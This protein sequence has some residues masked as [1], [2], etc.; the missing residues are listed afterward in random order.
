[1]FHRT[2]S[3]KYNN[4]RLNG[5]HIDMKSQ[6]NTGGSN[7]GRVPFSVDKSIP[8]SQRAQEQQIDCFGP[9][10]NR[11]LITVIANT[12][13]PIYFFPK[14]LKV[15]IWK[16]KTAALKK[17]MPCRSA[18][19]VEKISVDTRDCIHCCPVFNASNTGRGTKKWK[20]NKPF[21]QMISLLLTLG[22]D[23]CL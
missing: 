10:L 9:K 21:Y 13:L 19:W 7:K 2:V 3:S 1:M 4:R 18:L 11:I 12:C 6:A 15:S 22:H 20:E 16:T 17:K 14:W 23:A 8:G 5:S